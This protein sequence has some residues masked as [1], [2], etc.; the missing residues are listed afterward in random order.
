MRCDKRVWLALAACAAGAA[1]WGARADE[2]KPA[3]AGAL[4]VVDAAGKEQKVTGTKFT[5][6]TRRLT[7]L[8]PAAGPEKPANP[9][10]PGGPEALEFRDDDSTLFEDGIL[11]LIP[12]DRLRSLGLGQ[13]QGRGHGQGGSRPQG[14]RRRDA[15]RTD[16]L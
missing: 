6:G 2:P 7:W 11:T 9:T 10:Q 5:L 16:R 13:R 8:A 1:L 3:G 4:I 14:R 12:L 15:D